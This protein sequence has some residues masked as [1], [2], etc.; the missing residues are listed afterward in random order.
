MRHTLVASNGC[1]A[2]RFVPEDEIARTGISGLQCQRIWSHSS[3]FKA[4][5][6]ALGH[7]LMKRFSGA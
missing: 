5:G 4:L 3:Y 1:E 2:S 6:V 7:F